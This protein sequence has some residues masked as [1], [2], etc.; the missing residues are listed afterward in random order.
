MKIRK[1]YNLF[2]LWIVSLLISRFNPRKRKISLNY[3]FS[4]HRLS[5]ITRIRWAKFYWNPRKNRELFQFEFLK[6]FLNFSISLFMKIF[7]FFSYLNIF[8]SFLGSHY[9]FDD[10]FN[11]QNSHPK[12]DTH[13]VN[14]RFFL[15]PTQRFFTPK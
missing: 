13:F 11:F 5:K 2:I 9:W 14:G 8:P 4:E 7:L 12:F 10:F 3:L 6:D 1:K 15:F